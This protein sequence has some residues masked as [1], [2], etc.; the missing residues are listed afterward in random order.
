MNW[1]AIP[2]PD[3]A[4]PRHARIRRGIREA[5]QTG[6][7]IPGQRLP[8]VRELAAA[9]GVNRLTVLKAV[10]ALTRAGLLVTVQGRGTFVDPHPPR[11]DPR[12]PGLPRKGP[13]FEGVAE[14]PV[15]PA[16]QQQDGLKEVID[17]SLDPDCI[18]FA[19]GFPPDEAIPTDTIRIRV[20]H[21]LR[22]ERGAA[23]L[24]YV[25]TEGEPALLA[26]LTEL[27]AQRGLELGPEDR[28]LITSGA[29][30]G[31][32]LCLDALVRP[33]EA[34][35]METP[36]YMG[37]IAA[38]R[39]K[40][41][42]MV[43]VPVDRGG[44]NPDRLASALKRNDVSVLYTV[45]NHQNPTAATQGLRR[46]KQLLEI[47]RANNTFVIEDDIYADL[48]FGGHRLPPLKSLPG[49]ERVIYLGSFSKSLAPGLRI[50]FLVASGRLVADLRR[51]KEIADISTGTLAQALVADL[52]TSGFYR[53]HL[54]RVRRLYRQRRDAMLQALEDHL[55]AGVEFTRPKGG[56]HLW[57]MPQRPLDPERLLARCRE[58]Q[59]AFSPGCL[60][61]PD[62]RRSSSFRLNYASQDP[63]RIR[64][65]VA[66]LADCLRE[67]IAS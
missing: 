2:A 18:S 34:A 1:S 19:A 11:A 5:I 32:A 38:C 43:A 46:R 28:I 6:A 60:F 24:G 62:G 42:P 61:F 40:G 26:A 20:G 16:T 3:P 58:G 59:V 45:P 53:R 63:E 4:M 67:E 15:L 13:F 51:F 17:S 35:A 54:V 22:D 49:S 23:R 47:A 29:Q 52:L 33:G 7:L 12:A 65:G 27:L 9:M 41:I 50:G 56:L 30:Q 25:S 36:G 39:L 31:V 10:R 21:L 48:R 55:P 14:G 64:A 57:V 8:A 37:A 44:P 66:R